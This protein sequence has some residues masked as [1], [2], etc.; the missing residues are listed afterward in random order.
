MK[1]KRLLI[2]LFFLVSYSIQS[3]INKK[4]ADIIVEDFQKTSKNNSSESIYLQTNK[5]VYETKEDLWFKGYVLNSKKLTPSN[6]SKT[7]FVQLTNAKNS[8]VVWK[9]KYEIKSGFVDGHLYLSDTLSSGKYT[10]EAYS[11]MSFFN[12]LKKYNAIREVLIL[13]NIKNKTKNKILKKDS[14]IDFNTFP[15]SGNIINNIQNKIAF[16]AVNSKGLPVKVS[17][18]LYENNN[19]ILEFKSVHNGMGSFL[20]TPNSKNTYHIILSKPYSKKYTFPKIQTNG[21]ALQLLNK[22]KL[23]ATF[24][25][26]KAN[27]TT[28]NNPVYLRVQSRGVVHSVAMTYLKKEKIIKI[29]I[30][31]I[32]QGIVEVTLLDDYFRPIAERL[33]YVNL[34]KKLNIKTTL[35]KKRF[36]KRDKVILKIKVTDTNNIPV[37]A[38]LGLSVF[39]KL[40]S[41]VLDSKNILTHFHLSTQ[42]KGKIYNPSYYFDKQNMNSA[43]DLLLLTQG[44]RRYVWNKNN[45]KE[46]NLH[47]KKLISDN[48]IGYVRQL[49]PN[50]NSIEQN[51]KT[52]MVFSNDSTIGKSF[53]STNSKGYFKINSTHL[54]MGEKGYFYLK[55][56]GSKNNQYTIN[57]NDNSFNIINSSKKKINF[58]YPIYLNQN[59]IK[60]EPQD[61]FFSPNSFNLLDEVII[62]NKK[63]RVFR[64]KYLGSLDSIAKLEFND[65]VCFYNILNCLNHTFDKSRRPK[66]GK[67]YID[68]RTGEEV[69]YR[70]KKHSEEDLLKKFNLRMIKG[71]YG[72]REFY[73]PIYDKV[74]I[75]NPLPDYRNTLYWNP[76]IITNSKGEYNIEFFTSD[77]NS[78]YIGIIEGLSETG[79]LGTKKFKLKIK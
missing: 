66:D 65:Y 57:I 3:Q 78:L 10:L 23:Y 49:N 72:K 13:K 20:F 77:I 11:S 43:I 79:V 73:H 53:I 26:I 68:G 69:L 4:I 17:G 21:T 8:K 30:K 37:K 34:H 55:P 74:T 40:Y 16:K 75:N 70:Y 61:P 15:E 14:V 2:L 22:N 27:A 32:P 33:I 48:I 29:P 1:K 46:R 47:F 54:K 35:N 5:G 62:K 19:P 45:L 67:F 36:S 12:G 58:N 38:H 39:D 31:N 9:E 6:K 24:K 56:F 71:Y 76:N 28:I 50:K 63:K 59:K 64:D 42:L 41:N 60:E 52:V 18:I 44:W 25:I 51:N 7:L